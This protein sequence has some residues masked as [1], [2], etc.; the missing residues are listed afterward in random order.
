M[1]PTAD[2]S[3]PSTRECRSKFITEDAADCTPSLPTAEARA[4]PG[5]EP[6]AAVCLPGAGRAHL[7]SLQPTNEV[8]PKTKVGYECR[9]KQ[10]IRLPER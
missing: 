9:A 2:N 7:S 10:T 8:A 4:I 1:T 5:R 3:S 6:T